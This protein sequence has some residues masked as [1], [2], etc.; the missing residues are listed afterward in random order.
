MAVPVTRA[1][2]SCPGGHRR[3]LPAPRVHFALRKIKIPPRLPRSRRGSPAERRQGSPD[4]RQPLRPVRA[5][6]RRGGGGGAPAVPLG[7]A[8]AALHARPSAAHRRGRLE[9]CAS[10]SGRVAS[11]R[12]PAQTLLLLPPRPGPGPRRRRL[13]TALTRHCSIPRRQPQPRAARTPASG[14]REEAPGQLTPPQRQSRDGGAAGR[15][16]G[17][18]GRRRRF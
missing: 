17:G 11:R 10:R 9:R 12:G 13:P 8:G 7:P 2:S 5:P 18:S 14:S 15:R 16:R 4:A 3:R 1:G 6:E